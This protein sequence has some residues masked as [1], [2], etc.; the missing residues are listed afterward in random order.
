MTKTTSIVAASVLALTFAGDFRDEMVATY[1][2]IMPRPVDAEARARLGFPDPRPL[3]EILAEIDRME[4]EM[5]VITSKDEIWNERFREYRAMQRERISLVSELEESG[6]SGPRLQPLVTEKLDDINTT[7]D[8]RSFHNSRYQALRA[9]VRKRYEGTPL[10]TQARADAMMETIQ[11]IVRAGLRV[12]PGDYEKLAEIEADRTDKEAGLL[13][14]ESLHRDQ[15]NEAL[16]TQ[17]QDWMIANLVKRSLGYRSTMQKRMIGQPLRIEGE[18]FDGARLDSADWQGKVVLV[19][20]WGTWC[21]PCIA[22]MPH[23][24]EMRDKYAD[25]GLVVVGVLSDHEVD[26]A[27]KFVVERGF[28]WPQFVDRSLTPDQSEHPI[29]FDYAVGAY[30]TL[31]II[32]RKGV[33]RERADRDR[34][35][36]QILKYLDE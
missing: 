2:T 25:R 28:D 20:F 14:L 26:K 15:E 3:S 29:A 27:E 10:A 22:A 33:F 7:S 24:K 18:G 6:Y 13:L 4:A 35:E 5:K 9:D 12:H 23:L 21:M 11:L 19:D 36:E 16:R 8:P 32:D 1:G 17:W 30:P 34:L 31:W